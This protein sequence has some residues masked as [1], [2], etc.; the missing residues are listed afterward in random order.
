[1][2]ITFIEKESAMRALLAP[3]ERPSAAPRAAKSA[4]FMYQ[5]VYRSSSPRFSFSF[6]FPDGPDHYPFHRL[7]SMSRQERPKSG[8]WG[9]RSTPR[10]AEERPTR[11][12]EWPRAAQERPR[13]TQE[14]L[15][16]AQML[17]RAAEEQPRTTQEQPRV[18]QEMPR[19]AQEWPRVAGARPRAAQE[20][21]QSGQER[22]KSKKT[23]QERPRAAYVSCPF[24]W[25]TSACV[26]NTLLRVIL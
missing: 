15:P 16:A 24:Q 11:P 22:P 13:T 26:L 8:Q 2:N 21:P 3:H 4:F 10:A 25:L 23:F 6:P 9:P 7:P 12:Q 1:M 14:R 18:A 19:V 20:M 17:P 5:F